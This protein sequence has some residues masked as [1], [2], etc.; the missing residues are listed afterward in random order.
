VHIAR[1]VVRTSQPGALFG[2]GVVNYI[3][4]ASMTGITT[5]D[6]RVEGPCSAGFA[7][8][9]SPHQDEQVTHVRPHV[10]GCPPVYQQDGTMT[11]VSPGFPVPGGDDCRKR[12]RKKKDKDARRKCLRRCD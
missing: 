12:C 8:Y 6:C 2:I 7:L 1:G 4:H 10:V 5:E 3:S 9:G 11:F